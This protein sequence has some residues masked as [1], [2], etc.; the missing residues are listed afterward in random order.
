MRWGGTGVIWSHLLQAWRRRLMMNLF[1]IFAL[2]ASFT[3]L[4]CS[5]LIAQNFEALSQFW[6]SK[7]EMN[8]YLRPEAENIEGLR[9]QLEQAQLVNAVQFISKRQAYADLQTQ[10]ASSAPELLKDPELADFIPQ[11]F[12]LELKASKNPQG[13]FEK[14]KNFAEELKQDERIEDVQ[15]GMGLL[16]QLRTILNVFR[17]IGVLLFSVL[18]VGSLFMVAFVIRN[19]LIQRKVEIEILELVGAS[20][21]FIRTPFLIEGGLIS[22]IAGILSLL[23]TNALFNNVKTTLMGEDLFIFIA[24]RL[25]QFSVAGTLLFGLLYALLG[26]VVS[27]FCLRSLNTGFAAAEAQRQSS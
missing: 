18:L 1:V 17:Q 9:H 14:I 7:V 8:V 10:L 16:T 19:S 23:A 27:Y 2:F 26:V 24:Y 15:Y 13:Y 6:G 22:L 3:V 5:L 4:N 12:L 20:R 11:S 21:S 25:N